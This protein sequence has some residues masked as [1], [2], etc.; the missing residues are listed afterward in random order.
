MHAVKDKSQ[1][2]GEFLDIFLNE[3]GITLCTMVKAGDNGEPKYRWKVG[4]SFGFMLHD[5]QIGDGC[6]LS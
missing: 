5:S 4:G 1:V 6:I 3:K 2:L